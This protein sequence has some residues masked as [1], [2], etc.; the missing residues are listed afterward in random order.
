MRATTSFLLPGH[1]GFCNALRRTLLSDVV[2]EAPAHVEMKRN[3]TCFTDEFL[4]HRVGLVPFER[5][6]VG[7]TLTLRARGPGVVTAAQLAGPAFVPVFP[8]VPLA[9]LD[10]GHA[11]ELDVV[12]DAQA[13]ETHARYS[14]CFAVGMRPTDTDAHV[15]S[16]G[17]NDHRAPAALLAEAFD[18]LDARL[19]RALR[20]LAD[21]AP[22]HVSLI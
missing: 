15:L 4:A 13:A 7:D 1:V 8:D 6:G 12:F 9:L 20:A 2:T 3:G 14:P 18:R 5:V 10:D 17:S 16:F 21:D 11:L 19:D 22:R